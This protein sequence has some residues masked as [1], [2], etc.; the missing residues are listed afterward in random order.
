MS[1]R[2]AREWEMESEK[3]RTAGVYWI[4]GAGGSHVD[5]F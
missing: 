3:E 5:L 1:S 2:L 4:V